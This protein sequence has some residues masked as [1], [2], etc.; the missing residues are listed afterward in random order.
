MTLNRAALA[1]LALLFF[2]GPLAAQEPP[3]V[4][5]VPVALDPADP[6]QDR[7]G[8]LAYRG[9]IEFEPGETGIGGISGLEWADGRLYA[10]MDDGRWLIITPKE[11]GDRLV[12]V[13]RVESGP[14]LDPLGKRARR[15]NEAD[16]EAIARDPEGQWLIAFEQDHRVWRYAAL[17]RPAQPVALPL[18]ELLAGA[19]ANHGLE[20]LAIAPDGWLACRESAG[21]A[22]ANCLRQGP[23]GLV[24]ITLAAPAPLDTL[25]GA[26][27]DAA[28][29]ANGVCYILFRSYSREAGNGAAVVA[30]TPE[31]EAVTLASWTAP[32]TVANF[33]GLAL[34]EEHGRSF[35]YLASDNNFSASQRTLIL[36][37]EVARHTAAAPG[38]PEPVYRTERVVLETAMGAITIA[39]EVERAPVS[40]ANFLRYVDEGRLDGV[41]CYRAMHAAWGTPPSGFL[42]C[43]A[44]NDPQRILPP[45]AHEPTNQTGLSHTD[46]ALSMARFEPGTA[47]G[48]F[49][50]MINDQTGLD[51]RP[52]AE[53]PADRPG[54]AVFG[55]VVEGMEVVH[56]IHATP[57]DP[58][59]GEGFLKGQMLA[60]PVKIVKARRAPAPEPL[61]QA[62]PGQ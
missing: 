44:Q 30:L 16:A 38:E 60:T 19:P 47:T 13:D 2:P 46:G 42:Q 8:E 53:N 41:L 14:L 35:L 45:I 59:K 50:I 34:R 17:D 20:A 27:T 40:A 25:G 62:Q 37:F 55:Q 29:A 32:L 33:E 31:G 15:K 51:A 24:P 7:L 18:G 26:P 5:T 3:M 21:G 23:A 49:S 4:L 28:C 9:G 43:G 1:A 61:A 39:L 11:F 58:V 36:K 57:R 10:V 52:A 56:A 6:A 48:D 22:S 12:D 54:Y